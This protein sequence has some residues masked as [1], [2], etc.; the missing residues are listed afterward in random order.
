MPG[1]MCSTPAAAEGN[2][3]VLAEEISG[4]RVE[5]LTKQYRN[6]KAW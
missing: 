1:R 6:F 4:E 3:Y 5:E 2:P